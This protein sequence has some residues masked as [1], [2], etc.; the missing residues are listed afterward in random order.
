MSSFE[1]YRY[2]M[3][4]SYSFLFVPP[5]FLLFLYGPNISGILYMLYRISI[6]E[7]RSIFFFSLS[8][9]ISFFVVLSV[10]FPSLSYVLPLS[11]SCV[12]ALSLSYVFALSLSCSLPCARAR[13]FVYVYLCVCV[14]VIDLFTNSSLICTSLPNVVYF[15]VLTL[16]L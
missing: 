11:L 2:H 7:E 6:T 4:Y 1:S 16:S 12:F 5:F 15:R 9:F 14:C 10:L 13:T 3:K 8:P